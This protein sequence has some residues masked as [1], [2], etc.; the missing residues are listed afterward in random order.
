MKEENAKWKLAHYGLQYRRQ[1]GLRDARYRCC[2]LPLCDLIDGIDVV[3]TL[4][5]RAAPSR[6]IDLVHR[7]HA[8]IA[9]LGLRLRLAPL[10][11]ALAAAQAVELSKRDRIQPHV[12]L[13]AEL[14]N[15]AFLNAPR[16]RTTQGFLRL[17]YRGRQIDAGSRLEL[18]EAAPIVASWL[19]SPAGCI[20]GNQ[21]R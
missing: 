11:V 15:F 3:D 8:Q 16:S 5:R 10:P 12:L 20:A 18:G 9:G 21:A 6:L 2:H 19:D 4:T 7:I 1:I 17:F 13:L 14:F